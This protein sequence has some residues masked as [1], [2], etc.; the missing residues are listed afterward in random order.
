MRWAA[1]GA[2]GERAEYAFFSTDTAAT[3]AE[4]RAHGDLVLFT[5]DGALADEKT[6]VQPNR[7]QRNSGSRSSGY[8]NSESTVHRRTAENTRSAVSEKGASPEKGT[9]RA[10]GRG[11]GISKSTI[12]AGTSESR[13][14]TEG[15]EVKRH[16]KLCRDDQ[17][18][19]CSGLEAGGGRIDNCM[20]AFRKELNSACRADLAA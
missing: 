17:A 9:R 6:P 3:R 20:F 5:E 10:S 18:R 4:A 12:A 11:E 16:P 7:E 13:E 19:L 1:H 14:P 8:G 15:E 2:A